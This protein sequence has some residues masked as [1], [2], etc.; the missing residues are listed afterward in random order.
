MSGLRSP[1]VQA[2]LDALEAAFHA[3]P[4]KQ[5]AAED[6]LTRLFGAL[7][8]P[9]AIAPVVAQQLPVCAHLPKALALAQ[10]ASP[11]MA[12]LA[13]ALVPLAGQVAWR[14]RASS[15]PMA[16]DNWL[17]GHANAVIIGKGGLEERD[18][19]AIGASLMAPHVRY[20]DH[21]HAPEELY[22][23][24]SDSRFQNAATPWH[25]P[26]LGGTV[27]NPPGI[28]HAMAS[29]GVPLLAIWTM[30]V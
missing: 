23:V 17:N 28:Q 9:A 7:A 27:H 24:M 26:G 13:Q 4:N 30:V 18:D 25:A 16:S 22:M 15:G 10:Q 29:D 12:R 6:F 2:F 11:A 1:E 19:V 8:R 3:A 5:W 21:T 20:P 14:Q